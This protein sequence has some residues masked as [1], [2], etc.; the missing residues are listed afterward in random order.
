ML[1]NVIKEVEVP[2]ESAPKLP[3]VLSELHKKATRTKHVAAIKPWAVVWVTCL[4]IFF[5]LV[6]LY[7]HQIDYEAMATASLNLAVA[8]TSASVGAIVG[9][10]I[11]VKDVLG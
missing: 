6:S 7:A 11:A 9:E 10:R 5:V 2:D 1:F 4:I 3:G 8:V